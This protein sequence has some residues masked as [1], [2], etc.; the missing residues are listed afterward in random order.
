[1]MALPSLWVTSGEAPAQERFANVH[2][3]RAFLL[4]RRKSALFW[5]RVLAS[6]PGSG[7]DPTEWRVIDGNSPWNRAGSKLP[8][9][10]ATIPTTRLVRVISIGN[11]AT[12]KI[13]GVLSAPTGLNTNIAALAQAE[14]V[15][16][17]PI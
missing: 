7:V 17:S 13:V 10:N 3:R 4:L 9:A 8:S 14:N 6:G 2:Y 1:M 16:L 11:R 15:S 12:S 5:T